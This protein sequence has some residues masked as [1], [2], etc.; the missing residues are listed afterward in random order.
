MASS[1]VNASTVPFPLHL[2]GFG[3]PVAFQ[4]IFVD[5]CSMGVLDEYEDYG[6]RHW[7][8]SIS[9]AHPVA[10]FDL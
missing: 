6:Y 3:N 4:L 10:S 8:F 1:N 5:F 2:R 7:D 9:V